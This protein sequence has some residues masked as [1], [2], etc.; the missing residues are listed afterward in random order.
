MKKI[1]PLG[2]ST[3]PS[4]TGLRIRYERPWTGSGATGITPFG[5]GSFTV[6]DRPYAVAAVELWRHSV[7]DSHG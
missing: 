3:R 5:A 2:L 4:H 1:G 6:L 7:T